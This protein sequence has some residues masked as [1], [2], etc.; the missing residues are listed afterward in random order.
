MMKP[1]IKIRKIITPI[2]I[3]I[4]GFAGM[5]ILV[6]AKPVPQKELI[7][8]PGTL[9]EILPVK[10]EDR[11]VDVWGTGTVQPHQEAGISP[12]VSGKIIKIAPNFIAG[13][14][15]KKG[16]LLFEID[17]TDYILAAEKCGAAVTQAEYD[18]AMVESHARIAAEEWKRIANGNEDTPNPLV[19]YEPQLKNVRAQLVSAKAAHKQCRMDIERTKIRA[20]FNCRIRSENID[21]GQYVKAGTDVAVVIGTDS[22]DIIVPLPLHEIQWLQ[23]PKV[24]GDINGSAATVQLVVNGLKHQWQGQVVRSLGDVDPQGR[25]VRLVVS[26]NDPYNIERLPGKWHADLDMG[27]LVE[28]LLHGE[29]LSDVITIPARAVRENS[30]VW[31]MNAKQELEIR[32]VSVIRRERDKVLIKKGI[33]DGDQL[34]LTYLSGAAEGMKLRR[35]QKGRSQ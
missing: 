16:D 29:R 30:T 8:N 22:A 5:K 32:P 7:Q 28:V 13:G 21:L 4:A 26:V 1:K 17:P 35:Y 27:M 20:P 9:V 6:M 23:V 10:T 34:V 3:L 19:L 31:L 24:D 25:M 14:F 2:I 15:F 12:Q 18:L 11:Q 33:A